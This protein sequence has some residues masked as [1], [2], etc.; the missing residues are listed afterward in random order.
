[1]KT[2]YLK[3]LSVSAVLLFISGFVYAET[4][5]TI[6]AEDDCPY[7]CRSETGYKGFIQDIIGAIFD[8]NGCKANF[9][10]LPWLR[11]LNN[12]NQEKSEV[13]GMIGMKVHPIKKEIAIYPEEEVARYTH[14]FYAL[15]KSPLVRTWKYQGTE[16]LKNLKVGSV[17]GWN[18]CDKDITKYLAG[19]SEP[20]VQAL[21]GEAPE[22]RNFKKLLSG[23]IELWIANINNTE[24]LL[25]NELRDGNKEAERITGF[26][27][28]PV[29]TEVNVY[30]VFYKN[31]KGDRY[32]E[33][34]TK[35]IRELRKTGELIR[36]M[37]KYGLTD[38]KKE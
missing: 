12:F 34:F 19:G 18:Y 22:K 28:L 17:K 31:E 8:K 30:P 38:W 10:I 9:E 33:I 4:A 15:K 35:G 20:Y 6:L 36:I 14:R 16:S 5:I 2:Y 32:A 25:A 24:Y 7:S 29:T 27:D 1:M 11:I 26:L 21:Y 37:R 3:M 23:R 13:D